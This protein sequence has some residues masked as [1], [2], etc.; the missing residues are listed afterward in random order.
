MNIL[1][2]LKVQP[3]GYN[4]NNIYN[5]GGYNNNP[6]YAYGYPINNVVLQPFYAVPRP[7]TPLEK[8][9]NISRDYMRRNAGFFYCILIVLA[10]FALFGVTQSI[11]LISQLRHDEYGEIPRVVIGFIIFNLIQDILNI[12]VIAPAKSGI[13]MMNEGKMGLTIKIFYFTLLVFV[14]SNI[15][16]VIYTCEL[17]NTGRIDI[18][19]VIVNILIGLMLYIYEISWGRTLFGR[20]RRI[21][22]LEHIIAANNSNNNM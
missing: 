20:I 12:V 8:E 22:E 10:V 5:N 15:F 2:L 11:N 7:L 18:L 9:L 16:Y 17:E 3:E 14:I 21:N 1:I 6:E 13:Y 4:Y 19:F